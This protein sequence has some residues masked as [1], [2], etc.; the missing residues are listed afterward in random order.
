MTGKGFRPCRWSV[1]N[2]E[3]IFMGGAEKRLQEGLGKMVP[4]HFLHAECDLA[5][6]EAGGAPRHIVARVELWRDR[7]MGVEERS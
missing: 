4:T 5:P 6:L 2:S 3:E 1:L 7:P